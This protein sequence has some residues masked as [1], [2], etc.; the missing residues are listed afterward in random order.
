MASNRSARLNSGGSLR[1]VVGRADDERRRSR[2]RSARS[3]ACR[4][5]GPRRRSRSG[6]RRRRRPRAFSTSSIMTTQGAIASTSRSAW[7]TLA[8]VWPTSEPSRAPTSRTSVGRPVSSPR[9][10]GRRRSCP[11]PGGPS[12]S[13]PRARTP[14]RPAGPQGARAE[15]LEGL[16]AAQ[17]GERLAAP[18]QGQQARLLEHAAP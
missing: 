13:T 4:T 9:R 8:S 18:V 1:D 11:S 10:L 2:G 15:R 17:V 14:A 7:R 12:R 5:A 3:A 16:Q 6:R